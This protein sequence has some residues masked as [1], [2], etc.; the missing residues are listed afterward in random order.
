MRDKL[1]AVF[2]L[3]CL[4]VAPSLA[5][6]DEAEVHY[7]KCLSHKK[8]GKLEDAE[9]ECNL[10]IQ[11]RSDHAAALYTLA[12]LERNKGQLD[13]A[14]TKFRTVRTFEPQN[15]LGWAGEGSVLLRLNR[16]DEA[17]TA[18]RQAVAL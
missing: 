7:R 16:F 15:N 14:L 1:V 10:A 8:E 17:V 2:T 18:L 4:S 3:G 13:S 11:K 6:A 12:S 5:Y 9:K